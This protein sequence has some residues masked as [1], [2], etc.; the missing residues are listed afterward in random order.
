VVCPAPGGGEGVVE[1]IAVGDA[2]GDAVAV[3]EKVGV[4]DLVGVDVKVGVVPGTL[5][6]LAGVA[7]LF[8]V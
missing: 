3:G 4:D 1:D 6:A 8:L 5:V 2:D 7:V